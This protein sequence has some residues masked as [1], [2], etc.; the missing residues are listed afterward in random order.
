MSAWYEQR[1]LQSCA[2][3]C[4]LHPSLPCDQPLLDTHFPSAC[5]SATI[6]NTIRVDR[7]LQACSSALCL[8]PVPDARIFACAPCAGH[9]HQE[10]PYAHMVVTDSAIEVTCNWFAVYNTVSLPALPACSSSCVRLLGPIPHGA[11][12][13][14]AHTQSMELSLCLGCRS[15]SC[16]WHGMSPARQ[17]ACIH[18]TMTGTVGGCVLGVHSAAAD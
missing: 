1:P 8:R 14:R 5:T 9:N 12:P 15:C 2:A 4:S 13:T 7:T 3:S 18:N 11:P 10:G 6:A 16:G 17:P